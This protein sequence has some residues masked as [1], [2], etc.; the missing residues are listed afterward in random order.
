MA[1]AIK[2]DAP[3]APRS[4][5]GNDQRDSGNIKAMLGE[6]RLLEPTVSQWHPEDDSGMDTTDNGQVK[7]ADFVDH[8]AANKAKAEALLGLSPAPTSDDAEIPEVK[9]APKTE[10]A[11]K[12]KPK[13]TDEIPEVKTTPETDTAETAA[14]A[15]TSQ[16]R[17]EMLS[18]LAAEKQ[19]RQLENTLREERQKRAQIEQTLT[20]G[21][22][23][24]FAKA[25]GMTKEQAMDELLMSLDGLDDAPTETPATPTVDPEVKV[26]KAK[27]EAMEAKEQAAQDQ[28]LTSL[29]EAHTVNLD[30]PFLKAAKEVTLQDA[31]GNPIK[32]PTR[33]AILTHAENLWKEAGS[34]QD[35]A[36]RLSFLSKAAEEIDAALEEEHR[37][38]LEAFQKRKA[39]AA[40][41]TTEAPK[42]VKKANVP[43]VGR[44]S[45][46]GAA[47]PSDSE[48]SMDFD[49]RRAQIAARF[50]FGN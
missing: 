43:A 2:A 7:S 5:N 11:P 33:T 9:T 35:Q 1:K 23:R 45:G 24:E 49:E 39:K 36:A 37:P 6:S 16:S 44:K 8:F 14:A 29:V 38:V 15:T 12:A 46:G 25:R 3:Q 41:A 40:P 28:Q 22:I 21:S 48:L 34:P 13:A 26:I 10:T 20:K 50:G 42:L 31:N 19:R 18:N 47:K 17:K 30:V 4:I 27:L 32:V